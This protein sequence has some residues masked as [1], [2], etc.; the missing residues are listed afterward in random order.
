MGYNSIRFDDEVTRY[1]LYRNFFDP[2]EREWKNGNSRWDIIDMLRLARALRPE[3]VNWPDYDDGSP[4]FKLE[5]LTR[6]N[7]LAHDAAHDA[8]SDVMATIAMAR[9]LRE[10]QPRLY[11]YIYRHRTRQAV[12]KLVDV[13]NQA[14]FLHVSSRLPRE[15]SYLSLM[16]P[17]AVS[18]K[19]KNEIICVNLNGAIDPLLQLN[20]GQIRERLYTR[21]EDLPEGEQRVPLKSVHLNRCPVVATP[22]LL[23][24]AA[25]Q[26]LGIDLPRCRNNWKALRSAN[27]GEKLQAVYNAGVD[28]DNSDPETMLYAGFPASSDKGLLKEVRNSSPAQ[29]A[30]GSVQFTDSRYRELLF[31]YRA[32]NYPDTLS[33]EEGHQW[34]ELRFSHLND[35]ETGHLDLEQYHREIDQLLERPDCSDRDRQILHALQEWGAEIL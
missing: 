33:A 15:N 35:P 17:L 4:C 14:P 26:R 1:T 30:D 25:A 2:Y 32:R 16:M 18:P 29:L 28:R 19:N 23:D 22:G 11:D 31:R 20:A 27:L 3:G 21:T 24:D 6:A 12:A 8:L 34:E 13:F 7:G 10:K 5:E 9:L